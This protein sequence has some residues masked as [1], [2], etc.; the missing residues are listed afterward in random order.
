MSEIPTASHR[1]PSRAALAASVAAGLV[2]A[3]TIVL[4]AHYGTAVFY[5]MILTGIASCF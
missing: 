5:E 2:V 3:G 1:Q 4:W